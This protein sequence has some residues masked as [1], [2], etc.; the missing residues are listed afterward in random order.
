MGSTEVPAERSALSIM[1]LLAAAGARSVNMR[2]GEDRR[3]VGID[4]I[5][6]AAGGAELLFPFSIPARVDLLFDRLWKLRTGRRPPSREVVKQ[7]AERIAWR[8]LFR[9]VEAQVALVDTGMVTHIEVFT[10]YC[11]DRTGR[12]MFEV[13]MSSRLKEL[14][15]GE[16]Q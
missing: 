6:A 15:A 1:Q 8:Q 10:P 12:T 9:W 3:L 11:I 5:F 13:M 7:Q 16:G 2:Y 4:F 14:T